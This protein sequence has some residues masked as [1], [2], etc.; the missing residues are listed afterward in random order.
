MVDLGKGIMLSFRPVIQF[1]G[2]QMPDIARKSFMC[3][4]PVLA[5]DFF[6][7]AQVTL[8]GN[9]ICAQ[10]NISLSKPRNIF[11]NYYNSLIS[12]KKFK[13]DGEDALYSGTVFPSQ[14]GSS[15]VGFEE[16]SIT[17]PL[18]KINFNQID[19]T[20][21]ELDLLGS[22]FE[23]DPYPRAIMSKMWAYNQEFN[24]AP[25]GNPAGNSNPYYSGYMTYNGQMPPTAN[26]GGVPQTT[27]ANGDTVAY[28]VN[29]PMMGL[30]VSP[31]VAE[32]K[33][34]NERAQKMRMRF[35]AATTSCYTYAKG[36][37]GTSA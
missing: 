35:I 21:P 26:F 33:Q 9:A 31:S 6:N 30:M 1:N 12:K 23:A 29:F 10:S 16:N 4:T 3:C 17:H 28:A 24:L 5:S 22:K 27:P 19:N 2:D 14:Y 8:N 20:N 18:A 25:T 15:N 13:I 37:N 34:F 11:Q 32:Y 36:A 7:L